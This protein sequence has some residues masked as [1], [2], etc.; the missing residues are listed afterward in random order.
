MQNGSMAQDAKE[1]PVMARIRAA[2]EES[3]MTQQKL[4]E[5]MGYA[6]T[7]ARQAVSRFLRSGDPHVSMVRR[8]AKALGTKTSKLIGE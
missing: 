3:G 5:A 8:V 2:V 6:P 4:G 1:D 7:T